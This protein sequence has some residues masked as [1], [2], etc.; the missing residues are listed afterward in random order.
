MAPK[1]NAQKNKRK[2]CL[3]TEKKY[4]NRSCWER[5]KQRRK[6]GAMTRSVLWPT[7]AASFTLPCS[8]SPPRVTVQGCALESH[9]LC[10]AP[11]TNDTARLCTCWVG[12]KDTSFVAKEKSCGP[13]TLCGFKTGTL[14]IC[15]LMCRL[16][17]GAPPNPHRSVLD[18]WQML[19]LR[20]LDYEGGNYSVWKWAR[21]F[22]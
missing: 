8:T 4:K 19:I 18:N 17:V 12:S 14:T 15:N 22:H 6:S 2:L 1:A 10:A 13:T 3:W 11:I 9:P 20:H 7:L 5:Q 16:S 21:F